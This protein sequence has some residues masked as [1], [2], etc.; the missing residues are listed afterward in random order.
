MG[1]IGFR[2]QGKIGTKISSESLGFCMSDK[3]IVRPHGIFILIK[4]FIAFVSRFQILD[5]MSSFDL[6]YWGQNTRRIAAL[7]LKITGIFTHL[8]VIVMSKASA[9]HA[10][11]EM[12][13]E[14]SLVYV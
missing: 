10:V 6:D 8:S 1:N 11:V 9:S 3:S 4:I 7:I 13:R 2:L 14:K 12:I 5:H